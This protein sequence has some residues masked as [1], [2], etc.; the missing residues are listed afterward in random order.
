L[1]AVASFASAASVAYILAS[2]ALDVNCIVCTKCNRRVGVGDIDDCVR[3]RSGD[4]CLWHRLPIQVSDTL[5]SLVVIL[6]GQLE[7]FL[8]FLESEHLEW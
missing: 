5:L 4:G 2:V 6:V 1:A 8:L 7:W 3:N